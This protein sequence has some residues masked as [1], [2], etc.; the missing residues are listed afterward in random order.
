MK[1]K[2]HQHWWWHRPLSQDKN[3]LEPHI[4]LWSNR[5][6][7]LGWWPLPWRRGWC[8]RVGRVLW[9]LSTPPHANVCG[10]VLAFTEFS[11]SHLRRQCRN[12]LVTGY[13]HYP[14][15][16]ALLI[17]NLFCWFGFLVFQMFLGL[18]QEPYQIP[19]TSIRSAV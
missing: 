12:A 14:L 9:A 8:R 7:P 19:S 18:S 16:L 13:L 15:F 5:A 6:Y 11:S 17:Y 10:T 2:Y 1:K 4:L 3:S